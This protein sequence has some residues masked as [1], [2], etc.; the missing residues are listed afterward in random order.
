MAIRINFCNQA[1]L[2]PA[3][4]PIVILFQKQSSEDGDYAVIWKVIQ[5]CRYQHF[6]PVIL[7]NRLSVSMGDSFGNYTRLQS[8]E[9]GDRFD[10][11]VHPPE[12]RKLQRERHG[13]TAILIENRLDADTFHACLFARNDLLARR[14]WLPPGE[15][16]VFS[17]IPVMW[18]AV[19][20]RRSDNGTADPFPSAAAGT[21]HEGNPVSADL[22]AAATPIALDGLAAANIVMHGTPGHL[23]FRREG[24]IHA[25]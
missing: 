8:A 5:H 9:P 11:T 14:R 23:S 20:S 16:V 25:V 13:D 15:R 3:E 19:A 21:W 4:L 17:T 18:V 7:S 1:Q 10:A 22:L 6:H 2:T 24:V 12:R